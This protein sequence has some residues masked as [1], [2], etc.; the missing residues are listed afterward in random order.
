MFFPNFL[1]TYANIS[2]SKR[3]MYDN[4]RHVK[5]KFKSIEK[6]I[7]IIISIC[8]GLVILKIKYNKDDRKLTQEK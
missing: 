4:F 1:P 5:V 8:T 3:F 7:S 2:I 6:P